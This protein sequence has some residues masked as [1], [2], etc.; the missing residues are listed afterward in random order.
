MAR[1]LLAL[2]LIP[3][4]AANPD[5]ELFR[6]LE[7]QSA[8]NTEWRQCE[9][10]QDR[11]HVLRKWGDNYLSIDVMIAEFQPSTLLGLLAKTDFA[12]RDWREN[13]SSDRYMGVTAKMATCL[14]QAAATLRV[15]HDGPVVLKCQRWH[16]DEWANR[17]ERRRA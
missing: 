11:G 13:R 6:L 12:L 9:T 14:E 17:L 8:R 5:M 4:P 2:G 3:D 10:D 16:E 7:E 1:D 15:L